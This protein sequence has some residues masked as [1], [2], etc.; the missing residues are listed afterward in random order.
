MSLIRIIHII[1]TLTKWRTLQKIEDQNLI[2]FFAG[3]EIEPRKLKS[4]VIKREG[5]QICET[6]INKSRLFRTYDI[7]YDAARKSE[8]TTVKRYIFSFIEGIPNPKFK[9]ISCPVTKGSKDGSILLHPIYYKDSRKFSHYD[10][11]WFI[12]SE[13]EYMDEEVL[14]LL[15]PNKNKSKEKPEDTRT[16]IVE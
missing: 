9:F 13:G 3:Y 11:F 1:Y 16:E 10:L 4:K 2:F 15:A 8:V 7:K 12:A 5:E 6:R 14:L